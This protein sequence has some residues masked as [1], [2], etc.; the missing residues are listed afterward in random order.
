MTVRIL[1]VV[2]RMDRGGIQTWLMH[3]L[4][5]IDRGRYHMDFLVHYGDPPG[6]YDDEIRTLGSRIIPCPADQ[7][8]WSYARHFIRIMRDY[9]PFDVVHSHTYLYSGIVM[10]LAARAGVGLRVTHSHND[11]RTLP[12]ERSPARRFYR[13]IMQRLIRRYA[14]LKLATSQ[15]AAADMFGEA[16]QRRRDTKVIHCG[17]DFSAFARVWNKEETRR[18][19]GLPPDALVLGHVGR[20]VE[21]KNHALLIKIAAEAARLDNRICVLLIGEGPLRGEVK[22][23]AS[24]CGI[25]E[26]IV[27][28]GVRD[29]VPRIMTSGMDAFLF[30]SLH[31]GLG[32]V[33]VEAQAAG[34]PSVLADAVPREADIVPGLI[35]RLPLDAPASVWASNI[36]AAAQSRPVERQEALHAILD[37]DFNIDNCLQEIAH[38][39]DGSQAL[40]GSPT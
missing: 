4:R 24:A 3:L 23:Q 33:V 28:A 15:E 19:L 36:V 5:R 13:D 22:A 1:Q 39:Y 18:I 2:G 6:H 29:D 38:V 16:W 21:Q 9:G 32:L 31:E 34:L 8:P 7:R 26:R 40:S 11:R 25:L 37:S 17:L 12:S 35:R 14:V 27:F 30:P 10:G 20:F